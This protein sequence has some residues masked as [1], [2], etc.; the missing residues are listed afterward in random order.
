MSHTMLSIVFTID[1]LLSIYHP[2]VPW[3]VIQQSDQSTIR[4]GHRLAFDR[5]LG[6][7][8]Q[9]RPLYGR[10]NYISHYVQGFVIVVVAMDPQ[11]FPSAIYL[12]I[13]RSWI[14]LS[15]LSSLIYLLSYHSLPKP[16]FTRYLKPS[17]PLYDNLG[18][19]GGSRLSRNCR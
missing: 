7:S 15:P 4:V 1:M 11:V 12:A 3:L 17:H 10:I 9:E 5:I 18:S 16:S 2:F 13:P 19:P 8:F 14:S 6:P